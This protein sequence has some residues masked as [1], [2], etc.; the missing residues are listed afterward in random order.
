MSV[1][2]AYSVR[3]R[4]NAF[5][6]I[7]FGVLL[8][9]AGAWAQVPPP[10]S[11][12]GEGPPPPFREEFPPAA[13]GGDVDRMRGPGGPG[14]PR[15]KLKLVKQFDKDGDNRLNADERKAAREFL[16]SEQAQG[17]GRRG[18][19]FMRANEN[20]EPPQPGPKLTPGEVK[21]FG[22]TPLYDSLTLRTFFL[23]FEDA[24][25]EKELADFKNTDVQVPAKLSV[26]GKTY[27]AVGV[28]F[29]GMSSFMQVG[30]GQKRSLNL[31]LG[32]VHKE[33]KLLGYHT[34]NLLNSHED[35][36]FLRTVLYSQIAREYIPAPKANFVRVVINGESWGIYVNAQQFNKD[37]TRDFFKTTKGARWHVAG[38]PGGRGGL[39]YLGEDAAPYKSIYSIKSKDDPKSWRDLIRLCKVLNETPANELEAVLTPLLDIDGA[40]KFFALENVFINNDGFWTRASDYNIY[41]DAKGRFHIIPHDINETFS[42]PGGPGFGGGPLNF[43]PRMILARQIFAAADK[44]RDDKLSRQEFLALADDWFTKF[45]DTKSGGLTHEQFVAG[46]ADALPPPADFPRRDRG[47]D[48]PPDRNGIIIG[49]PLFAALDYDHNGTLTR[50]EMKN[51]FSRWFA[52]WDSAKA[53]SISE[54]KLGE[55]LSSVLPRPNFGDRPQS[56]QRGGPRAQFG[57]RGGGGGPRVNIRG[58]ELDPLIATNDAAKPLL[59]K[60]LAV[61]ALRSRYLALVHDIAETWLDWSKLG[62]IAQQYQSLIAADVQTDTRKLDSMEDFLN[63]LTQDTPGAS[64]RLEGGRGFGRRAGTIGLKPFVEQRRAYLLREEP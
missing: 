43:G 64:A 53:G 58:V 26:D 38:S 17:R 21:S 41:Q 48:R 56:D 6:K 3:G 8:F 27:N 47:G 46:L 45:D 35:P 49:P 36:T 16:R 29:R 44:N 61:P 19:R 37:F 4:T 11:N 54:E 23:E 42:R 24:D 32:F 9:C 13:A 55:G 34:L 33:Q 63:G 30:E 31:S 40:L 52:Q 22:D 60:L 2:T 7:T 14:G 10:D 5:I 18:P 57:M 59:S 1:A 12:P 50:M 15:E 39:N 62:P 51:T 28:H 20:R 25:W